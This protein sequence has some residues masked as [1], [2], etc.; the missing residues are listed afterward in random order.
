MYP[1]LH[2][3]KH[4]PVVASQ[5]LFLQDLHCSSHAAPKNPAEQSVKHYKE[6]FYKMWFYICLIQRVEMM[7]NI[8]TIP[9][10]E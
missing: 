3:S 7:S 6:D 4:V 10:V 8:Y 1:G 9:R 2:P 5:E